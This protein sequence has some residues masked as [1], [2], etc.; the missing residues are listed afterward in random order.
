MVVDKH[1]ILNVSIQ[2]VC[3]LSYSQIDANQLLQERRNT[4]MKEHFDSAQT[5]IS[6]S[7]LVFVQPVHPAVSLCPP[8]R[9]LCIITVILP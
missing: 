6:L 9:P 5:W 1:E 4:N 3:H 8:A 7:H 2:R